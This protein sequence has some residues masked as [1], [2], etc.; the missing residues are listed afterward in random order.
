M[1]EYLEIGE[2]MYSKEF[3]RGERVTEILEKRRA[4]LEYWEDQLREHGYDLV[5]VGSLDEARMSYYTLLAVKEADDRGE[6]N[7]NEVESERNQIEYEMGADRSDHAAWKKILEAGPSDP[8]YLDAFYY[9]H[10]CS[11]EEYYERN[12]N[13]YDLL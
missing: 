3:I 6:V 10:K 9:F 4:N 2:L 12:Q 5:I 7:W 1:E 11:P 8:N 13:W